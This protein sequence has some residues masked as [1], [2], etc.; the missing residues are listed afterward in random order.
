MHASA[1]SGSPYEGLIGFSR[2]VRRGP[3]IW[4]AGTGPIMPDGQTACPGDAYGQAARCLTIIADALR[5]LEA[6]PEHVVRTRL[7]MTDITRWEDAC[8]AHAEIFGTIR[9]AATLMGV[10][11]L[12]RPDWLIEV[13]ADAF[14][15]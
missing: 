11:A 12:A 9:P 3:H 6:G 5:E 13:E 14:V 1:T 8:R 7:L 10:A 2:A 4:I 15:D